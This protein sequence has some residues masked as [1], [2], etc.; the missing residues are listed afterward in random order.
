[1]R[2]AVLVAVLTIAPLARAQYTEA[3]V[4]NGGTISGRITYD[5]SPP[6]PEKVTI[7]QDPG[8]CGTSRDLD[9]WQVSSSGGV[10]DVVV[11]LVDIKSGKK[12]DLP[13]KPVLDQKGCRYEPH[14]QIIGQNA[15]LQVKNSDPILHNIHSYQ[16]GRTVL[17]IAEPKQG[18]V[19]E[20]KMKKAGGEALKC[21]VHNFMR[22]SLFVADNP[23][24]VVTDADG[25]YELKD[26][27][28]GTYQ[29]GTFHE[30]AG[31]KLGSV[32]VPAGGK[33][34]FDAKIKK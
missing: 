11:Y 2:K 19:V 32:T 24:A 6:K 5:G 25:K 27:P 3:A 21:D 10:K 18:M 20:K 29:I 34:T 7:T 22:G 28:A 1:M 16:E 8:T 26:V 14:A 33:V 9:E 31:T 23:Y 13:A 17:N 30:V 4:T 12:M 15:D